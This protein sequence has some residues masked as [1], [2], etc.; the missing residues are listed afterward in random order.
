MCSGD[1]AQLSV[2]PLCLLSV[3]GRGL[4]SI[5]PRVNAVI[6]ILSEDGT[7]VRGVVQNV[8]PLVLTGAW[9]HVW[10]EERQEL[11]RKLPG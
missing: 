3:S 10:R 5:H 6:I 1:V 9:T 11:D 4:A 7:D 8:E 2:Y